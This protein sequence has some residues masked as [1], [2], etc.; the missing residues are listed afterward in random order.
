MITLGKADWLDGLNQIE[1]QGSD[2]L[3]LSENECLCF[4]FDTNLVSDL[5]P[6]PQFTCVL[7]FW[8]II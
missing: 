5:T 7:C 8:L 4:C 6:S 1:K 2:E 3:V